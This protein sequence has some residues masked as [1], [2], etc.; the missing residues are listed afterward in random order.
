MSFPKLLENVNKQV[1][2]CVFGY[3][4]NIELLFKF[5]SIPIVIFYLCLGYY[6]NAEQFEDARKDCF[7]I[8]NDKL[9]ITNIKR[10]RFPNHTIYLQRF[11]ESTIE[12]VI[13]WTFKINRLGSDYYEMAFAIV[14]KQ[15]SIK[16]GIFRQADYFMVFNNGI[17]EFYPTGC[18]IENSRKD[19]C[20]FTEGDLVSLTLDLKNG[21]VYYQI[22]DGNHVF[23]TDRFKSDR[24]TKYKMAI[25]LKTIGSS[26]TL[27]QFTI[28]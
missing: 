10:C 20:I 6:Y 22:N 14:S 21:M 15:E 26:V 11:I 9:T 19:G 8:S 25:Q 5:P 16:K 4:R 23:I 7:R 18:V 27:K 1:K 13:K 17:R 3:I 2:Y 28:I 12:R 24:S